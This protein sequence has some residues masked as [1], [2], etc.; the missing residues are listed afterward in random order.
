MKWLWIR[1]LMSPLYPRSN[2]RVF[3]RFLPNRWSPKIVLYPSEL[4]R[5]GEYDQWCITCHLDVSRLF[6]TLTTTWGRSLSYWKIIMSC[7]SF[8]VIFVVNVSQKWYRLALE[9][10]STPHRSGH[11]V[12]RAWTFN[13]G[14]IFLARMWT[15]MEQFQQAWYCISSSWDYRIIV[16]VIHFS[17]PVTSR[18]KNLF[19]WRLSKKGFEV[20]ESLS[21]SLGFN[22]NATQFACFWIN[23][24][25]VTPNDFATLVC[26]WYSYWSREVFYSSIPN[27]LRWP[28]RS[29]FS[30]LRS[31]LLKRL[32]Y[33]KH[34]ESIRCNSGVLFF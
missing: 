23:S 16:I 7:W 24:N 28:G 34:P 1:I 15:M 29:L 6:L 33:H 13:R 30:P 2:Q 22:S 10:H 26:I 5:P 3:L 19:I 9:A 18:Y 32:I 4:V 25:C 11:I 8:L 17:S 14:C 12:C 20:T 21:T 27:F 31:P